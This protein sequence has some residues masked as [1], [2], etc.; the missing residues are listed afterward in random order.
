YSMIGAGHLLLAIARGPWAVY[1]WTT[2][3]TL[4]V[5]ASRTLVAIHGLRAGGDAVA[6]MAGGVP[7]DR[8]T[9]DPDERRLLNVVDEMAIA[10]GVTVPRVYVLADEPAINA[11]A[12]GYAPNQAVIAVTRGA[13]SRLTRDELQGVIGHEFSHILNGDMR[14]NVTMIGVLAGI[15]FIGEIGRFLMRGA[16]DRDGDRRGS[17]R[18]GVAVLGLGLLLIGFVGLF[19][20]R[21]IKS[22]LSRQREF[23]ADASSVQFT[24]NPEGLAG[25]LTVIGGPG[26]GSMV[27]SRYA[28][29]LSHMLFASGVDWW[30]DVVFATHPPLA[31]R[32]RRIDS[33]FVA[34]EYLARRE[35]RPAAAPAPTRIAADDPARRASRRDGAAAPAT[36]PAAAV[37]ASV[38]RPERPH[39]E[40]AGRV[41]MA[42]P[43]VVRDA[44]N[45][46]EMA[47]ALVLAF[48][49]SADPLAR[50]QQ[51]A[52]LESRGR[53][54]CAR[55]AD[56]LVGHVV[57]LPI[58]FRL[59]VVSL[60]LGTLR[61]LDQPA[62]DALVR[63]LTT[64]VEAD[65]RVTLPE[66]ALLTL[67]RQQLRPD[68][69]RSQPV[70][71]RSIVDVGAEARLVL[72]L[73]ARAG[74][75]TTEAA[76][77]AFERGLRMLGLH[78]SVLAPPERLAFPDVTD[79][80][81]R[82]SQL[83]P[84]VK[85][86]FL[87]ACIETVTTDR[88]IALDE[89][90]LLRAIAASLDCPVPPIL[91]SLDPATLA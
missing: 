44:A 45:A 30:L 15:V 91:E 72:G 64:M 81:L 41:L 58:G 66:F 84:F 8:D 24:R 65:Q 37:I 14:L 47:P 56:T 34:S 16:F 60:A 48:A 33:R 85:G 89:A 2:L 79:A 88:R 83:T 32:V 9:T 90:E 86:A 18:S 70:K 21:V 27:R 57:T 68:A 40:Y 38:G 67:A 62:R 35:K 77:P 75:T 13:L 42:L 80:L 46:A 54:E 20:G 76:Y 10:S 36:K 82:L 7:I 59:P 69:A 28:E 53:E 17:S 73:L 74:A 55:S 71:Y 23:L 25:A 87:E 49:L 11:F 22:A 31:E 1:V 5:I 39:V 63:D 4:A 43:Q 61:E 51:L 6:R 26:A 29:T 50:K 3:V 19:F 52:L 78:P 12:A